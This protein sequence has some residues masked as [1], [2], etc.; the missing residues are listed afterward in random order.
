MISNRFCILT[1]FIIIHCTVIYGQ[2][3]LVQ[4]EFDFT[5]TDTMFDKPYIDIDEWRDV[6]VLHRYVHGGFKN[7]DTRFSFYF[8]AK[9]QYGGRFFQTGHL[10][11]NAAGN[12]AT[13]GQR[14]NAIYSNTK[15]RSCASYS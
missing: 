10:F 2:K 14:A 15:H 4:Q 6:P 7:T 9:E 5:T 3:S 8:P 13:A 1:V 12:I 11:P